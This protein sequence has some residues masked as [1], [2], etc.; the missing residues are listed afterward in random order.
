MRSVITLSLALCTT[1]A[2]AEFYSGNKLL[3]MLRGD[4]IQEMH[5]VGYVVGVAD[6]V[7]GALYCPPDSITVGQLGDM[8]K[9]HLADNPS[10]RHK[11]A[12]LLVV[13][14]LRTTW[15]CANRRSS[16]GGNV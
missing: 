1:F 8:V 6:T 10:E 3:S 16:G 15:P 11:T 5:A 13:N 2:H 12:D 4:T 9:Q 14:L 7:R